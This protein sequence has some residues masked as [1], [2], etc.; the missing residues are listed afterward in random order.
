MGR[1][2]TRL[3]WLDY[4]VCAYLLIYDSI[5][6]W[7]RNWDKCNVIMS[8]YW[9]VLSI[10]WSVLSTNQYIKVQ[11]L[12][13]T[14]DS[15]HTDTRQYIRIWRLYIWVQ[16][17]IYAYETFCKNMHDP[18]IRT[19]DLMH[20]SWLLWPL[21]HQSWYWNRVSYD[22]SK[23][24]HHCLAGAEPAA[25]PAQAMMSAETPMVGRLWSRNQVEAA[26]ACAARLP[27]S[28]MSVLRV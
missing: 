26:R 20:T 7:K 11:D 6:I 1:V 14:Y 9:S 24:A 13:Y 15:V 25:P 27:V 3:C 4:L 12:I 23:L 18:G 10:Y 21:H 8:I 5:T 19:M 2:T 16:V 28:A 17:L 22:I